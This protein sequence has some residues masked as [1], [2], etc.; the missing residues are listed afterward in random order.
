MWHSHSVSFAQRSTSSAE[1]IQLSQTL[2]AKYNSKSV[3][4]VALK[5]TEALT[6]SLA[7]SKSLSSPVLALETRTH[8]FIGVKDNFNLEEAIFY[9]VKSEI[10]NL[11]AKSH[12]GTATDLL[13]AY[14]TY[15]LNGIFYSDAKVC[16]C[17]IPFETRGKKIDFSYEKR[18]YDVKYLTSVFFHDYFPIEEKTISFAVPDWLTIEL[19]EMN[20]E[21]YNIEE[22]VTNDLKNKTK[23]YSFTAKNL[24]AL[25]SENYAPSRAKNYP[26]I[27]VLCK[28]YTAKDGSEV[29]LLEST[30]E[31]YGWYASLVKEVSNDP[32][33]L[34]PI[35]DSLTIPSKTDLEKIQAIY[36]WVQDNIRYIAFENGIM[37]FKPETAQAVLKNKYGDCKGMANLLKEM[38]K[39]AGYDARLTWLGTR[40]I[41]YDYSTPSLCVDNHMICTVILNKKKYFLD[42]TVDYLAVNDYEHAIQGRQALIEDGNNYILDTIP[43]FNA[44]HNKVDNVVT[45]SFDGDILI[46]HCTSIIH[47]EEKIIVLSAMALIRTVNKQEALQRYLSGGNSNL[48]ISNISTSNFGDRQKPLEINY[49]FKLHNHS[50]T[51]SEKEIYVKIEKDNDYANFE[52]DTMERVNDCELPNKVYIATKTEFVIPLKYNVEYLPEPLEIKY[53]DFSFSLSYEL[54][55]NK[56]IYTKKVVINNTL[57]QKKDFLKWDNCIKAV[58]RFYKDPIQLSKTQ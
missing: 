1:N 41:P 35:V 20:F 29:K 50:T 22:S 19:K 21:G 9:D 6:F 53:T 17:T 27:L 49:D 37:G 33:I 42:A 24:P 25:K 52:I 51:I 12:S 47:G 39:I 38:L 11:K 8:N 58:I 18:Y 54:I 57:I 26:H 44:E 16:S 31:L 28:K 23:T 5:D 10:I 14:N 30:K 40:D 43:E 36:S 56:I 45:F 15:E 3:G 34:K 32:T 7:T 2:K 4:V 48:Q 13:P 55:K 46:G